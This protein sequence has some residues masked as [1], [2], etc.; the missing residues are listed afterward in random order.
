[1]LQKK[2]GGI[3]NS[4]CSIIGNLKGGVGKSTMTNLFASTLASNEA[5]K[6]L[7]FESGFKVLVID[8]DF[9]RTLHKMRQ[10]DIDQQLVPDE[11]DVYD[12]LCVSGAGL[13]SLLQEPN[14][15]LS[16]KNEDDEFYKVLWNTQNDMDEEDEG[17]TPITSQLLYHYTEGVSL[18]ENY[19]FMFFDLVGS[20]EKGS[21]VR[22]SYILADNLIIPVLPSTN[23]FSALLSFFPFTSKVVKMREG[24]E[25]NISVFLNCASGTSSISK[26]MP[27]LVAGASQV[28]KCKYLASSIGQREDFR[29]ITSC[30]TLFDYSSIEKY[31][32]I[33]EENKKTGKNKRYRNMAKYEF[34]KLFSELYSNFFTQ[35]DTE[36]ELASTNN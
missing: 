23:D 17:E 2:M 28:N 27:E 30:E 36:Q 13:F 32:Q 9:Q 15:E 18:L 24:Y 20:I 3:S 6:S 5:M 16:H 11:K 14:I 19:D 8:A 26:Q 12:V 34:T 31:N 10:R 33:Q 35:Q 25:T 7:G 4:V 29:K 1:M 21:E 22:R